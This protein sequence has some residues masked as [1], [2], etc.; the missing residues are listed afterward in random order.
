[1]VLA[2]SIGVARPHL[3]DVVDTLAETAVRPPLVRPLP[4]LRA[5][6]L[7]VVA[8]LGRKRS[9]LL[10]AEEPGEPPVALELTDGHVRARRGPVQIDHVL[11]EGASQHDP[12]GA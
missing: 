2:E 7:D 3:G 12:L 4:E 1:M 8:L 11:E 5:Q 6:L 9:E 10:R